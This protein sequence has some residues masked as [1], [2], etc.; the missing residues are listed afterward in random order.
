[1]PSRTTCRTCST[2][3]PASCALSKTSSACAALGE[4]RAR[5]LTRRTIVSTFNQKP[6]SSF[7]S[8]RLRTSLLSEPAARP[9]HAR[10]AVR[11][12]LF[13]L[14][15]VAVAGCGFRQPFDSAQGDAFRATS[16][17]DDKVVPY[18]ESG[19][20]AARARLDGRRQDLARCIHRSRESPLR[21]PLPRV[22]G[23]RH[24]LE[25][26]RLLWQDDPA[27]TLFP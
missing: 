19:E 7:R 2:R 6:R 3:S 13:A 9:A 26:Q 23:C 18:L 21:Q 25:R 16:A 17:Q 4:R 24:G 8:K 27:A 15:A 10:H 22:S 20:C 14:L 5:N 12:L 1:M 11:R